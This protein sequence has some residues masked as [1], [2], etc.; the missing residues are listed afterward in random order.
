MHHAVYQSAIIYIEDRLDTSLP[1]KQ[2]VERLRKAANK[3]A[4]SCPECHRL[5]RVRDGERGLFFAHNPGEACELQESNAT[6]SHQTKR[7]AQHHSV[8]R[9]MIHEV[10]KNQEKIRPSL[11]VEFGYIAKAGQKWSH[12]P[13][14]VMSHKGVETA[15]SV[16]T[17]VDRMKDQKLVKKLRERNAYFKNKGLDTLWF[18]DVQEQVIDEKTR[19]IYLWESELDL[20]SKTPQDEAW[21]KL[22]L[23][24][25]E[26]TNQLFSVMSYLSPSPFLP[27]I[28]TRSLFYIH[29]MSESI[30]FSVHRFIADQKIA[31]FQAFA[32]NEGYR[33]N[34]STALSLQENL[35]L[36]HEEQEAKEHEHFRAL[37][38]KRLQMWKAE[39]EFLQAAAQ[40]AAEAETIARAEAHARY[41]AELQVIYEKARNEQIAYGTSKPMSY[42][43]LKE[44]LKVHLKMT[45]PEQMLLWT[46]YVG[47]QGLINFDRLWELAQQVTSFSAFEELLRKEPRHTKR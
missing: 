40:A 2:A 41:E 19:A 22:L 37:Y 46:T 23:D 43:G 1:R 24:L 28:D 27:S 21:D 3:G 18:I 14:I 33:M 36:H 6:Y 25:S 7:E 13:D 30:E 12:L 20:S 42:N 16:L 15:I 32:V 31:P 39:Q 29:S 9:E 35:A 45:Q 26:D 38:E 47:R 4:Y 11:S 17:N 10:L 5:L 8:L 34:I 44:L